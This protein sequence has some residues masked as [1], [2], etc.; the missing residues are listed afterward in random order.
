MPDFKDELKIKSVENWA[1][2]D[3]S[4]PQFIARTESIVTSNPGTF[5]NW[6]KDY[7]IG[8]QEDYNF[9][10]SQNEDL[11]KIIDN[12]EN[13][14]FDKLKN[15]NLQLQNEIVRLKHEV[16]NLNCILDDKELDQIDNP[17]VS[18]ATLQDYCQQVIDAEKA[19]RRFME[20]GN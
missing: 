10:K 3:L 19:L 11:K 12:I 4:V 2:S 18:N 14:D 9:L 13:E 6:I 1:N 16:E 5:S 20:G 15:E 17:I 8:S 7:I